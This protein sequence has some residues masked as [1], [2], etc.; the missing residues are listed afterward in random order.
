VP[1][2]CTARRLLVTGGGGFVGSSLVHWLSR[3]L[4]AQGL[5]RVVVLDTFAH[6]GQIAGAHRSRGHPASRTACAPDR[7]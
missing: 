4:D 2:E 1:A 5:E 6:P 3:S 7:G